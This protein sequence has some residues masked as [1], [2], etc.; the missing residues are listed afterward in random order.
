M[1]GGLHVRPCQRRRCGRNDEAGGHLE[2]EQQGRHDERGEVVAADLVAL[3]WRGRLESKAHQKCYF[4]SM[5][6]LVQGSVSPNE[7][8]RWR[9]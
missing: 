2:R 1:A 7:A 9:C 4:Q 6:T 8:T 5:D 3:T